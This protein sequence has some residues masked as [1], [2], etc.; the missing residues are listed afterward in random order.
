MT[1]K[2]QNWLRFLRN[3]QTFYYT[4]EKYVHQTFNDKSPLLLATS[5]CLSFVSVMK[6]ALSNIPVSTKNEIRWKI[7]KYCVILHQPIM[8]TTPVYLCVINTA[9]WSQQCNH[10]PS[11]T[12]WSARDLMSPACLNALKRSCWPKNRFFFK[13]R[14]FIYISNKNT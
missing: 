5:L 7:S 3:M 11:L 1:M 14:R 9:N 6:F 4:F 12:L 8:H 13:Q 2:T 10:L